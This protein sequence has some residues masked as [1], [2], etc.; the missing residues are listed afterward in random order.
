MPMDLKPLRTGFIGAG[1][2]ARHTLY[3]ALHFA[4]I[5]LQAICEID[6]ERAKNVLG[7]F[8]AGKWYTD[9]HRMWDNEDIEAM[10]ICT[11]PEARQSLVCEALEAG[12]HV[13]VPKPPAT[14]LA[15]AAEI[16]ETSDRTNKVVMVNFQRRFSLGVRRAMQIM[17]EDSFGEVTQLLGSFCSGNYRSRL[18]KTGGTVECGAAQVYLLDFAIHYFDLIRYIGG[19]VKAISSFHNEI[20]GQGAFAVSLQFESGA[21]G[22]LQLNSHRLWGRNYDRVEITGQGEYIVLDGLWC[23]AHYT[24]SQ[25]YFT[26]NYSDQRTGELT[27]D[28]YS[29]TEFVSAIREEREP[30]A[31]IRDC[32]GTMRLYEAVLG[33][34]HGVVELN[35]QGSE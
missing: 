11:A 16:A 20:G 24:E 18:A 31:S 6:E 30:I 10:I 3:P 23:V 22:T 26:D 28:G 35:H 15:E 33:R 8:G 32:L 14:T 4:P 12:F 13:F 34:Q 1:G 9:Y 25:N 19:E 7:K 29:L 21:V 5:T 2:F 17:R 27:G